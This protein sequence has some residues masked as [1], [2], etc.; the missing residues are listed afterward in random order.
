MQSNSISDGFLCLFRPL[1]LRFSY[2]RNTRSP[3]IVI[4]FKSYPKV[5][6]LQTAMESNGT[7][8]HIVIL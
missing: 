5:K 7:T 4:T 2:R 8:E 6:S 3:A 1:T